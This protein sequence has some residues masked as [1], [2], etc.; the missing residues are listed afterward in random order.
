MSETD[1]QQSESA[2][3]AD[4]GR[5]N[6]PWQRVPFVIALVLAIAGVAY[7]NISHQPLVGYWEFLALAI[8]VVCV[9]TKWPELD[10]KQAQFRLMWT[11]ALHWVAVLV[12]MNMML[13]SGV[14]QLLPTPATSLVLLTLLA[15]GTFLAGLSL[16]SPQICFLGIAMGAAVPA[17]SW[18]KQSMVFFLLAAVFVVG[19]GMTFWLGYGRVAASDNSKHQVEA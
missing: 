1:T 8:A 19:I 13:V 6:F 17:L 2:P 3:P 14:Q 9:V 7:T 4:S 11:Q 15:L 16:L 12:T 5:V 10:S 18:L